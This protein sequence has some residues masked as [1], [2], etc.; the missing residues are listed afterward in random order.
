MDE[1]RLDG[2]GSL[3]GMACKRNK[4]HFA[5]QRLQRSMALWYTGYAV[6][7]PGRYDVQLHREEEEF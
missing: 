7:V 1:T 5:F 6:S 4:P 3:D 2:T